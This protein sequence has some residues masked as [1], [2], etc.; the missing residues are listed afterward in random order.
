LRREHFI[1][2]RNPETT[3]EDAIDIGDCLGDSPPFTGVS[4][5]GETWQLPPPIDNVCANTTAM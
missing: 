3:D 2:G 5:W 1:N 4:R